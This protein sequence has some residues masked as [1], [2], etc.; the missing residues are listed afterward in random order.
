MIAF[1]PI[2]LSSATHLRANSGA[3]AP[4]VATS[5]QGVA[6]MLDPSTIQPLTGL[7]SALWLGEVSSLVD[8]TSAVSL[9]RAQLEVQRARDETFQR[10]VDVLA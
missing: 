1:Q 6:T 5:Q 4:E 8:Q 3:E 2:A 7:P 10:L 9:Y